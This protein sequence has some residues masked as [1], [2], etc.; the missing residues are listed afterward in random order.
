MIAKHGFLILL[1]SGIGLLPLSTFAAD[2]SEDAGRV[3]GKA[4]IKDEAFIRKSAQ[5]AMTET[6]LG[7]LAVQRGKRDDVKKLGDLMAADGGKL[8]DELKQIAF[9]VGITLKEQLDTLHGGV[10]DRI[11][12]LELDQFDKVYIDEVSRDLKDNISALEDEQKTTK[13]PGIR[14]FVTKAIAVMK[15][16]L[17]Q[18]ERIAD[19]GSK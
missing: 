8:A 4:G 9:K 16:H 19:G 6:Q 11:G 15:A 7:Q 3:S 2:E 1:G 5:D 13:D 18:T 17:K 10:V 12:K 14:A